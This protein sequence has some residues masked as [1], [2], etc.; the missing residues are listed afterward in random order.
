MDFASKMSLMH[1]LMVVLLRFFQVTLQA[2]LALSL[3]CCTCL[4]KINILSGISYWAQKTLL[5]SYYH[6][7]LCPALLP[8]HP[9]SHPSLAWSSSLLPPAYIFLF[10]C[11][12]F[13]HQ[14]SSPPPTSF[15][16]NPVHIL[17]WP[18]VICQQFDFKLVISL[19][20]LSDWRHGSLAVHLPI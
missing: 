14:I 12:H 3:L 20:F 15:V 6:W 18:D 4:Y 1:V 2:P 17:V 5:P 13:F 11:S 10:C 9:F 19:H 16:V 8:L 7:T